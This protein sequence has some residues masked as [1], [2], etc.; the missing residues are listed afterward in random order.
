[1]NFHSV[2]NGIIIPTDFNS[3]IFQRG[4]STTN[5]VSFIGILTHPHLPPATVQVPRPTTTKFA[6]VPQAAEIA[7]PPGASN[8][9]DRN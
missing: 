1:M 5:Q 9:N 8:G 2:G 4:R 6:M 3:I 7:E